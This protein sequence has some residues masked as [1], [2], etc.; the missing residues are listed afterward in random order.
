MKDQ[1]RLKK[2]VDFLFEVGMLKKTPRSGFQF[3]GTGKESVADHSFR[4]AVIGYILARLQGADWSKVV[5]MCLFHDL[6]EARTGDFNYV[7][8]RYNEADE[9][10]ALKDALN[11]TGFEKEISDIIDELNKT[12]TVES[13][14][15]H[16]SDQLDLIL[17]LKEQYDLGNKYAIMWIKYAIKRLKTDIAKDIAEVILNTDH[18]DWWFKG[19][20][21]SWW[22]NS[23]KNEKQR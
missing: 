18:T 19:I 6:V 20:D 5:L 23:N 11:N 13:N 12:D 2:I 3:L 17:T 15:A 10:K 22:S 7:N 16:D 8:K 21:P 4:S 1:D 9:K 14:L